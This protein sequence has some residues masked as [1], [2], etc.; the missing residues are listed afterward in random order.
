MKVRGFLGE[1]Y[2]VVMV[3]VVIVLLLLLFVVCLLVLGRGG[4]GG[5]WIRGTIVRTSFHSSC[6]GCLGRQ[7]SSQRRLRSWHRLSDASSRSCRL[8][9]TGVNCP[10]STRSPSRARAST[11]SSS[12]PVPTARG[13]QLTQRW[14]VPHL[15]FSIVRETQRK[16]TQA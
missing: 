11:P 7:R 2:V 6:Q 5:C 10:G 16:K 1:Q 4:G 9:S 12:D 8:S 14:I 15:Q 13:Q 3:V